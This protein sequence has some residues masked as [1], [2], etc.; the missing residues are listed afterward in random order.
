LVRPYYGAD[1]HDWQN[2]GANDSVLETEAQH[3][4][5]QRYKENLAKI[6]DL[7]RSPDSEYHSPDTKIIM[8]T[9]PPLI[10]DK[11]AKHLHNLRLERGESDL[12]KPSRTAAQTKQYA[13]A[14]IQVA[15]ELGLPVIDIHSKLIQAAGGDDDAS[16]DPYL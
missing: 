1:L 13:E 2:A 16:L 11:W 5:L 3:V 14:C 10:A 7:V 6:V 9:P 12:D 8:I 15:H 4:P